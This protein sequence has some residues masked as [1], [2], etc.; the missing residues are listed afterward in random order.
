[1]MAVVVLVMAIVAGLSLYA[2]HRSQRSCDAH[3]Y[4]R[5]GSGARVDGEDVIMVRCIECGD[6][7]YF[8]S[9]NNM[10]WQRGGG[11]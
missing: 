4:K 7:A 8:D 10:S 3:V 5:V 1:M 2:A 11:D 6:A 9:E